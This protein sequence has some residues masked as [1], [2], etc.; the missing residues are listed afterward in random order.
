VH[1][2]ALECEQR[3]RTV[4]QTLHDHGVIGVVTGLAHID[5]RKTRMGFIWGLPT[6]DV[7][8]ALGIEF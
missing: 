6:P 7:H 5:E 1:N 4:V 2:S 8:L 3:D